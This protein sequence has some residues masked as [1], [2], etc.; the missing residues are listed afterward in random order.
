MKLLSNRNRKFDE[1]LN[2]LL[3]NRKKKIQSSSISVLKIINDV[4]KNGDKAVIKYEKRFN[5]NR[6]IVPNS[7]QISKLISSFLL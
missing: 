7:K 3:L 4:K 5:K 1:N 2:K 6:V